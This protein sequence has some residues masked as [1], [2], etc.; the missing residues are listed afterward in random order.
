MKRFT[1]DIYPKIKFWSTIAKEIGMSKEI[2][3]E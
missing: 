2:R 1:F 3:R